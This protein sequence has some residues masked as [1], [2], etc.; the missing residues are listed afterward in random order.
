[1]AVIKHHK[2]VAGLPETLEPDSVYYV[3]AGDGVDTYVTNG[4]GLIVAYKV[5]GGGSVA[6]VRRSQLITESGTWTRPANMIGDTVWV[7]GI[8][9]GGSGNTHAN[10]TVRRGG[11]SGEFCVQR[12][13]NI[14]AA[15][16]VSVTVGDGGA[17][18]I[19][20]GSAQLTGN[21]GSPSSFGAFLTLS[22]GFGA[23]VTPT[24][25]VNMGGNASGNASPIA[26]E[27]G[28]PC[29]NDGQPFGGSGL[30]LD[31]SGI[32]GGQAN[33]S[34]PGWGYGGGG[35]GCAVVSENSGAGAPGAWLVEWDE[36]I[37][38]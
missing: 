23:G 36:V 32:S 13:V 27:F 3:R 20:N 15:E 18:L 28:A 24:F 21:N 1:M 34:T 6:V 38:L 19:A 29:A 30:L 9:G 35:A 8:G 10:N 5:N 26:G 31:A 16:S 33:G 4:A 17:A 25:P 14:G 7:T 22:G 11:S 12:P 2:V 37:E